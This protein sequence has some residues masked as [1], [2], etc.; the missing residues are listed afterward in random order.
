MTPPVCWWMLSVGQYEV[1]GGVSMIRER[2]HEDLDRLCEI[3]EDLELPPSITAGAGHRQWLED[4]DAERSWVFD[5]AP[6]RVTPT[7]NVVGHVQILGCARRSAAGPLVEYAQRAASE[8]LMVDK[9]FVGPDAHAHGIA[10]YLLKESV[11]FIQDQGKLPV[12]DLHEFGLLSTSFYQRYG[13][14]AVP[15]RNAGTTPMIYTA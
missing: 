2:R 14:A 12:V 7:K 6:V 11:R 5:K 9:L 3:L 1:V 15:C 4:H 10:R 13:F 8:L